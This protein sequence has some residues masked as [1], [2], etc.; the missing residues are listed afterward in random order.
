MNAFDPDDRVTA[1]AVAAA[2]TI[3]GA[4]VQLRVAWR[5]EVSERARGAPVTKKSRRG[6]VLA[7]FLLLIAAGVGGFA[8]SQYWVQQADRDSAVLRNELQTQIAQ[9]NATAQRLERASL[10]DHGAAA[11]AGDDHAVSK[12]IT[13]TAT[14]GP[15]RV[16]AAAGGESARV[17]SELEALRVTLCGSAPAAAAVT[18]TALY[19]RAENSTQSWAER[20]V[21]PGTDIGR[22]RFSDKFFERAESDRTKQICTEFS[23]W[24]SDHPMSARMDVSY[25]PAPA[26]QQIAHATAA[27]ISAAVAAPTSER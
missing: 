17:C 22:A 26:Q 1:A 9:I 3:I 20:K 5:K 24:D 23:S 8:L 18:S 7:V 15:C 27:P 19:A 11:R 13:V 21:A 16:S 14:I 10:S 2:G 12:E 4:L 25:E 6:P